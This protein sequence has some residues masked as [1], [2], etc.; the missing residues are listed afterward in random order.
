MIIVFHRH[1]PLP[2]D[3]CLHALQPVLPTRI[4]NDTG[5]LLKDPR[6]CAA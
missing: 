3:D 4:T 6:S 5:G 2:L 1:T